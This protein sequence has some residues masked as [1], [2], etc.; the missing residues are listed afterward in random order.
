MKKISLL[1]FCTAVFSTILLF[2]VTK[3]IRSEEGFYALAESD[4]SKIVGGQGENG[5]GGNPSKKCADFSCEANA[6]P[7]GT[8]GLSCEPVP[9]NPDHGQQGNVGGRPQTQCNGEGST[10]Y[11]TVGCKATG[12]DH[13]CTQTGTGAVCTT[14][15][16]S[17]T[18]TCDPYKYYTCI[19]DDTKKKCRNETMAAQDGVCGKKCP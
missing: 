9:G 6:M 14:A 13:E 3:S 4:I 5:G 2:G 1:V 18:G 7:T 17:T 15:T 19:W 11:V 10:R 16:E 12:Q 8:S